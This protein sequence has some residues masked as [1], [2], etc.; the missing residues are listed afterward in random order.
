MLASSDHLLPNTQLPQ[1]PVY[2]GTLL[3]TRCPLT[4]DPYPPANTSPATALFL[5]VYLQPQECHLVTCRGHLQRRGDVPLE[6]G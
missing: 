5:P 2:L 1:V 3:G 4:R 6:Q